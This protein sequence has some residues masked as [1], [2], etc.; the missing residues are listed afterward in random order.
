MSGNETTIAKG[1]HD[2]LLVTVPKQIAQSLGIGKG[3]KVRWRIDL[4]A[5]RVFGEVVI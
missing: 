2:Q 4:K 1:S 3:S 5:R